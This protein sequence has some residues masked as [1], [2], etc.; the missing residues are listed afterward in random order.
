VV[1]AEAAVEVNR[2]L[3]KSTSGHN[4]AP[5]V[6]RSSLPPMKFPSN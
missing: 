3:L 2:T 1:V 4:P 6:D 5:A